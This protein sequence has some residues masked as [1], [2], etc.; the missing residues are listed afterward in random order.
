MQL[1]QRISC[2]LYGTAREG[3]GVGS[4]Q[5]RSVIAAS[6]SKARADHSVDSLVL[7]R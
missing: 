5:K 7:I 6:G 2:T 3:S 1:S 4:N